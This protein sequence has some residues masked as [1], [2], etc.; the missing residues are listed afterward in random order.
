MA[1]L[2]FLGNSTPSQMFGIVVQTSGRTIVFDGGTQGDYMQLAELLTKEAGSHVDAWF[3]THA[4]YDHIGAFAEICRKVPEIKVDKVYCHF[5]PFELLRKYGSRADWEIGLW[6]YFEELFKGRFRNTVCK[7]E[8]NDILEFDEVKINVL[9][10][11][12]PDTTENFINNSSC[13]YRIDTQDKRVLIL[14]DLG[15]E[16]GEEVKNTCSAESLFADY[17]QMAHHGQ[18]GVN[19]EFYRYIRP[20]RCLWPA[21]DW[22]WDNNNGN[23]YDSGPW[24]TVETRRWMDEFEITEHFV[25]K[26]GTVRIE[27]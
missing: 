14:G 12:N 21:P 23:G 19:R 27:L 16:G 7:I 25:E 15:V 4:H 18:A 24:Q 17:T 13:V 9:R 1:H 5:P 10:V 20:Q 6:Q 8:R 2:Y 11:Y 22:L 3:F 26:D